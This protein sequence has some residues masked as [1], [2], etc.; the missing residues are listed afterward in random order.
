M[1]ANHPDEALY[2]GRSPLLVEP[3]CDHYAGTERTMLKALALQAEHPA[4]F[5][6]TLDLEDGAPAGREREQAELVVELLNSDASVR[7]RAGAR[8]HDHA[9]PFWRQDVDMLVRGAGQRLA[10]ITIPKGDT[11]RQLAE[12]ITFIQSVCA[13]TGI[14]REI[15][16]HVLI[17][18]HGALADA[19]KIAALPWLRGLD[20][21]IMDFVS[22]HH[23]AI[24][25][26]AMRSPLQFEHVLLR[27]AKAIQVTAALAHGLVPAHNVTLA[28][29]DSDQVRADA[30][31]AR[32]EFGYLRMWSVHPAQI[33]PII[34]AFAPG[35]DEIDLS[36]RVLCS[37]LRRSWAPVEVDDQLYDRASYRY[38][39][40]LVKRARLSGCE[41]PE[42]LLAAFFSD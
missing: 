42:D 28:V 12:M 40:Q 11:A 8:I 10:H 33:D 23:G 37:G 16:I 25:S 26:E 38:F 4:E 29:R 24:S 2:D 19:Y 9:S 21:G 20:F 41:L 32:N 17:E 3:A 5:D 14:Q 39:W 15:P 1:P 22:S 6:V 34:E 13:V 31:R 7:G 30:L 27:R 35:T 36:T 18:T